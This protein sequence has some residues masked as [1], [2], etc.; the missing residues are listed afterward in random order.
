MPRLLTISG[1][2]IQSIAWMAGPNA[3]NSGSSTSMDGTEQTFDSVGDVVSLQLDMD[4]K[5]AGPA[6]RERGFLTGLPGGNAFRFTFLD[7]DMMSPAEAGM[8]VSARARW[9]TLPR[10]NW[11][12]GQ[13][14]SNGMGWRASPPIVS[15][16]AASAYDSGIVYLADEFWGHSLGVGDHIGFFPFSLGIYTVTQVLDE[17][18][19]RVWPRLRTA[20]TTD[21]IGRRCTLRPTIV[22]RPVSK[23]VAQWSRA[24]FQSQSGASIPCVEVVDPYVRQYFT[25]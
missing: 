20:L 3:R 22:M 18:E 13:P 11:S 5:R 16:A 2:T 25:E 1:L 4:P 15:V 17:G 10:V 8:D 24:R 12:N 7:R 6:R 19:Y 14:W 23:E 21:G 9:E